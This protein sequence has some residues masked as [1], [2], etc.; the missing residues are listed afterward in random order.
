MRSL[1]AAA[2]VALSLAIYLFGLACC[3]WSYS[4]EGARRYLRSRDRQRRRDVPLR[5]ADLPRVTI[6]LPICNEFYV[7]E[8]LVDCCCLLDYPRRRFEIQVLDDSTDDTT[9][10]IARKVVEYA[11]K[12]FQV[13]HL[14]RQDRAGFKAGNL[15]SGLPAAS[16]DYLAIFD[17]DCVPDP[18]FL[19][20]T[21][22]FFEDGRVGV[23]QARIRRA[24]RD[25]SL[26]TRAQD[27][28]RVA[29]LG[30]THYQAGRF[31]NVFSG[32]AV[33]IRKACLVDAGGWAGDTLAED[34]DLSLR[35]FLGGWRC[36]Q[37]PQALAADEVPDTMAAFKRRLARCNQ[38][39]AECWRKHLFR[40]LA[41]EALTPI[42]KLSALPALH[43]PWLSLSSIAIMAIASVPLV[44]AEVRGPLL[45]IALVMPSIAVGVLL[46]A[47]AVHRQ[48]AAL[49]AT[50]LLYVGTS[51]EGAGGALRGLLGVKSAF[52]RTPK[53]GTGDADGGHGPSYSAAVTPA[54]F[55][56]GVLALYFL[57]GLG[58]ALQGG[59][60][61]LVPFHALCF[62]S[63]VA[64]FAVSVAERW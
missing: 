23:V 31:L 58:L 53:R 29:P 45:R 33:V 4:L 16:G 54:T 34:E 9:G 28:L 44:L 48:R 35:A 8:R 20:A 25:L 17:A 51:I 46:L 42:Q 13:T 41:A 50:I 64:V 12:G 61:W 27:P 49:A 47:V 63:C 7:V 52:E 11:A 40:V 62:V 21:L 36:V 24:N 56:E 39:P 32:S 15:Q 43:C 55:L 38:G 1:G 26:L 2:L 10:L 37:L 14:R 59:A 30:A 22:P 19:R 57:L 60:P 6:Q 18:D 3:L 5:D